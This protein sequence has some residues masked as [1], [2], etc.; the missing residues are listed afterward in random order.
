MGDE[1]R[2]ELFKRHRRKRRKLAD[3][4]RLMVALEKHVRDRAAW[5]PH[6][7]PEQAAQMFA[8]AKE[9]LR[10]PDR[11]ERGRIRRADQLRW[12][13]LVRDGAHLQQAQD[14]E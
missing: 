11:T 4:R 7:T 12:A 14:N 6:P 5:I 13:T 1:R 3:L 9:C 8:V 10:V 2:G